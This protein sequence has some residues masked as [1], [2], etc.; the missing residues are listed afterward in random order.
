MQVAA[1]TRLSLEP[2]ALGIAIDLREA[3]ACLFSQRF[4]SLLLR[5]NLC[6]L[7][8]PSS[9]A[10]ILN[11]KYRQTPWTRSASLQE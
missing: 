10:T 3:A 8:F 5:L 7:H 4:Q 6:L 9:H 2:S 1:H 11:A